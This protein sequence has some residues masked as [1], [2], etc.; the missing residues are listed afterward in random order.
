M[1]KEK[2]LTSGRVLKNDRNPCACL[3]STKKVKQ[4]EN[5]LTK[6]NQSIT[7]NNEK[8]QNPLKIEFFINNKKRGGNAKPNLSSGSLSLNPSKFSS[9]EAVRLGF[10][11]EEEEEEC[12]CEVIGK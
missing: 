6:L 8:T 3:E 4:T 5:Q 11:R 1:R 12:F 10:N 2:T 7:S 9:I